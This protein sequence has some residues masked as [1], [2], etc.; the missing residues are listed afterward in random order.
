MLPDAP[1]ANSMH[2]NAHGSKHPAHKIR[3]AGVG[4]V[5][6]TWLGPIE[7]IVPP[8]LQGVVA[9]GDADNHHLQM[10]RGAG[11]EGVRWGSSGV[12]VEKGHAAG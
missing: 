8:A 10:G 6:P 9:V 11:D 5:V 7:E 3:H 1:I 2:I 4:A 12:K